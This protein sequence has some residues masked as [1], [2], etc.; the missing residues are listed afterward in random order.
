MATKKKL[1]DDDKL[2]IIN[3]V[4]KENFCEMCRCQI[5]WIAE[6]EL[7]IYSYQIPVLIDCKKIIS[8]S[9]QKFKFVNLDNWMDKFLKTDN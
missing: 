5:K 7:Q 9:C 3:I 6:Y 4:E 8:G 2:K 1:S